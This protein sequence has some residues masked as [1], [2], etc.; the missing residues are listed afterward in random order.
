[1]MA[2]GWARN[3]VK[4][5]GWKMALGMG[6]AMACETTLLMEPSIWPW[7]MLVMERLRS[8]GMIGIGT[9]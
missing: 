7:I 5:V 6:Q 2:K 8:I 9:W 3:P 1:M 4:K